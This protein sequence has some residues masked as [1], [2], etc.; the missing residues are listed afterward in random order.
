M[1]LNTKE[2][3]LIAQKIA[4]LCQVYNDNESLEMA[5]WL[6]DL[7]HKEMH[8]LKRLICDCD[9]LQE[10]N[11]KDIEDAKKYRELMKLFGSIVPS[12]KVR[13]GNFDHDK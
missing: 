5:Q 8:K 12:S 11:K 6:A 2:L 4:S 13:E 7:I 10:S 9:N 3:Q 1:T